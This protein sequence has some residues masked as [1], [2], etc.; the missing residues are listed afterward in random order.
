MTSVQLDTSTKLNTFAVLIAIVISDNYLEKHTAAPVVQPLT[1]HQNVLGWEIPLA[2]AAWATPDFQRIHFANDASKDT[3]TIAKLDLPIDARNLKSLG[4]D[5]FMLRGFIDQPELKALPLYSRFI[6]TVRALSVPETSEAK[7]AQAWSD[8]AIKS[9]ETIEPLS[10]SGHPDPYL[11]LF[12][13][14]DHSS[15]Y[16]PSR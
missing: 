16:P 9:W 1:T 10:C 2:E 14:G 13:L 7:V 4:K 5:A 11:L 6:D 12:D 3:R 15:I 8:K